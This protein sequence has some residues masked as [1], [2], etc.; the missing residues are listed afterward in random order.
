[1]LPSTE[2]QTECI[3][4]HAYSHSSLAASLATPHASP[5]SVAVD[6]VPL[7]PTTTA[8]SCYLQH[9]F[10]FNICRAIVMTYAHSNL[11]FLQILPTVAFLLF[12]RTDSTNSPYCLP[13]LLSMT[14]FTF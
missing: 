2:G 8:I 1:M 5:L 14:F 10:T 6:D 3:G 9:A 13:I 12:F 7:K 11:P 4:L